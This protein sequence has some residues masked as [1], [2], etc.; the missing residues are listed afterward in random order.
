MELAKAA[1][2]HGHN[3]LVLGQP[4]TGKT[5][6]LLDVKKSLEGL[7]KKVIVTASTGI[8]SANIHGITIH[9]FL[10]MLHICL[11]MVEANCGVILGH[12]SCG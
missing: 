10:G 12:T 11:K 5:W 3:M 2:M 6:L 1:A 7:Q 9:K 4:G 8:A